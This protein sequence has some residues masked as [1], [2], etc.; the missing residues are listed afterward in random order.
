[1]RLLSLLFI[2][3]VLLTNSLLAGEKPRDGERIKLE[4]WHAMGA[5]QGRSVNDITELFN[6]SQTKWQV[7]AIYQGQYN[8]LSQ[9]LIASCYAGRQPA[10]SQ[11]YPSWA[12]RFHRYGYLIPIDEF[13]KSDPD[14]KKNDIPDFYPT[15]LAENTLK[16]PGKDAP[17]LVSLPF[18]KSVYMLCVNQTRMEAAGWKEPPKTWA[19]LRKLAE[20]LTVVPADG[21]PPTTFGFASRPLIED[22]TVEA[23]AANKQLMDEDTGIVNLDSP[24]VIGA[25]E[26]IHSLVTKQDGKQLGYVEPGYLNGAFGAEKIAMYVCSTASFSFN[27]SAVGNKFIWRAYRMPSRDENT[28]GKTLMQGTSVGIFAGLDEEEKQGAW[29]YLKFLTSTEMTAKWSQETGYMPVRRS[30]RNSPVLLERIK[31][32]PSFANAIAILED[33][34]FEPRFGWWESARNLLNR[35]VEAVMFGRKTPKEAMSFAAKQV[36]DMQK[37]AE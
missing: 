16:R 29:E 37:S 2:A 14:F 1:M 15:M 28:P 33:A 27:D 8:T 24:D 20:E 17:E 12:Y 18:N 23:F 4:F 5:A 6:K 22:L 3:F 36:R 34:S 7:R 32:D 35:E 31:K 13:L 9:K 25:M 30:A 10:L 26:F 21:G 19:E 11:M